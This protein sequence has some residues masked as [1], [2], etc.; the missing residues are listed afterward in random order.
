MAEML[1][2]WN[3]WWAWRFKMCGVFERLLTSICDLRWKVSQ[4]SKTS[5]VKRVCKRRKEI[6]RILLP[7]RKQRF[8]RQEWV[9]R[10][11]SFDCWFIM[12]YC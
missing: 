4:W 9:M 10:F 5:F 7:R 8:E 12:L 3:L 1:I 2:L 6:F 11:S